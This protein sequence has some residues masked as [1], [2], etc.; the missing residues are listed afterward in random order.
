ME[1]AGVLGRATPA[2]SP[3]PSPSVESTIAQMTEHMQAV[4]D[5]AERAATAIRSDAEK[6]A[7]RRLAEARREADRLTAARMELITELTEDFARLAEGLRDQS[8]QMARAVEDVVGDLTAKLSRPTTASFVAGNGSQRP[9]TGRATPP[10][11]SSAGGYAYSARPLSP[12]GSPSGQMAFEPRPSSPPTPPWTE[13][14]PAR[15]TRATAPDGPS[16]VVAQTSVSQQAI[17][18]ASRLADAGENRETITYAL[19]DLWGIRDPDPIVD[20]VLGLR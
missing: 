19:R 15:L 16:P 11:A 13:R 7:H 2:L 4:I 9:P 5:A 1:T 17:I 20:R 3:A 10:P 8:E 12:P 18:H 14:E 6:E